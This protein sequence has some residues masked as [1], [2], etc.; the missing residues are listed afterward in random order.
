MSRH[1]GQHGRL[2]RD[3]ADAAAAEPREADQD[4]LAKC[5]LHLEEV[6]VVDHRADDLAC[7]S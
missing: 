7:M 3:D 4:V 2:L 6:A 5:R 1:A